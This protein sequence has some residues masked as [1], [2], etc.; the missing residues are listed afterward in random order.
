MNIHLDITTNSTVYNPLSLKGQWVH[1]RFGKRN[2]TMELPL[3]IIKK[4]LSSNT[5]TS[6]VF[7]SAYGD[8]LDYTNFD[9]LIE[10]LAE[11]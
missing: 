11:E 8:P 10:F 1:H 4:V 5:I 2:L 7:E 3:D 9:Q 6:V